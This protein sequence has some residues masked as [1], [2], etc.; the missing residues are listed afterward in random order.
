MRRNKHIVKDRHTGEWKC[1]ELSKDQPAR[2]A[3]GSSDARAELAKCKKE[4]VERLRLAAGSGRLL[5]AAEGEGKGGGGLQ[6]RPV[7]AAFDA[8][9]FAPFASPF[10]HAMAAAQARPGPTLHELGRAA[11]TDKVGGGARNWKQSCTLEPCHG[12]DRCPS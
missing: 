1:T 8:S 6:S 3:A 9:D 11:R 12:Y 4:M 10:A 5:G 7:Q 2:A